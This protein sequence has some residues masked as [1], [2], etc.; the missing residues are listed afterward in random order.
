MSAGPD[1]VIHDIGF[2]HYEGQR[3]RPRAIQRALYVDSLRGAYGLGR[4]VKSKVVPIL[5]LVAMCLPALVITLIVSLTP[6]NELPGGYANYL[7]NVQVLVVIFLAAQ[8]PAI[9]SRDLRH[10]VTSLY[11]SRPLGRAQYV[12]AKFAA[13]ATALFVLLATP[14]VI[15]LLGAL[16]AELPFGEQ[17]PEFLRAIGGAAL[18]A[19]PLSGIALLVAALTTRRGLGVAAIMVVLLVLGGVQGTVRGIAEA[20]GNVELALYSALLSPF[21]IVDGISGH[22]LQADAAVPAD[23]PD[24]S[25]G[26]VFAGAW[27]L[28][29]G[30]AYLGLLWRYRGV[31]V[32]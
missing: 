25:T 23:P 26:L 31:S 19:I 4:S 7:A 16:L 13:M 12:Q 32:S 30:G 29:A 21:A 28:L 8:A 6:I 24:T 3:L 27:L 5:I 20:Q 1:G 22:L 18:Y 11:F 15:L 10:R 14:L 9:M 2:R 17:W